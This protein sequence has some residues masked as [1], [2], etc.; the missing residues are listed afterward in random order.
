MPACGSEPGDGRQL[1]LELPD[2]ASDAQP[3]RL[4]ALHHEVQM[5][6]A[7]APAVDR[8]EVCPEPAPRTH[9]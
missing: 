1:E 3:Q 9:A 7:V 6:V 5:H 8:I 2:E 4:H